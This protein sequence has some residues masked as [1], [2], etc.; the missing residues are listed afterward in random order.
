MSIKCYLILRCYLAFVTE[1]ASCRNKNASKKKTLSETPNA[2]G[3]WNVIS[4]GHQMLLISQIVTC[5][6]QVIL[7]KS[8]FLKKIVSGYENAPSVLNE[9]WTL[10]MLRN[11]PERF[12]EKSIKNC[13]FTSDN[14]NR[15]L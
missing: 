1:E 11:T 3:E 4:G 10:W 2:I 12:S 6:H 7:V 15:V 9:F 14:I 13:N 5:S 8:P